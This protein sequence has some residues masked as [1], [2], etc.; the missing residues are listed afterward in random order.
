[1]INGGYKRAATKSSK[2][3]RL[4]SSPISIPALSYLNITIFTNSELNQLCPDGGAQKKKTQKHKKGTLTG[5]EPGRGERQSDALT[6]H[7]RCRPDK[8]GAQRIS[9]KNF[10]DSPKIT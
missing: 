1:M 7:P 10:V 8:G 3:Q 2:S 6:A 9:T 5:F 4:E